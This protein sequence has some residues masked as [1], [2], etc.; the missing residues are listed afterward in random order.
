MS[1]SFNKDIIIIIIIISTKHI[2]LTIYVKLLNVIL[3]T[4]T[5]IIPIR[6]DKRSK[7]DLGNYRLLTLLSCL[8]KLFTS[9][10]NNRLC[11][12]I[13]DSNGFSENQS[14]FKKNYSRLDIPSP[15]ILFLNSI[16]TRK[17]NCIVALLI[18]QKHL[19]TFGGLVFGKNC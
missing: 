8:G 16:K 11:K 7:L 10:F 13:V 19:T 15:Y 14:G 18:S 2:L 12:Y 9:T 6:K 5:I 17:R 3:E 4:G 1:S